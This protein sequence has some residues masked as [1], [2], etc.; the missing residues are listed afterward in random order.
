MS[1]E[2]I[3]SVLRGVEVNGD[4]TAMAFEIFKRFV[5]YD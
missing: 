2:K 3:G 1:S 4:L 5:V